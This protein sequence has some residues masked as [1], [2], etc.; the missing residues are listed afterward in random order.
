M[1]ALE[2]PP[3]LVRRHEVRHIN[4]MRRKGESLLMEVEAFANVK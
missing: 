3:N 4:A 2:G 1:R